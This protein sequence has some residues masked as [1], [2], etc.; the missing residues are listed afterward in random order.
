MPVARQ[1][2]AHD[3]TV[4][5]AERGAERRGAVAFVI[6]RRASRDPRTKRQPG[7]R[8]VQGLPRALLVSA[9]HPGLV[10]R[11]QVQTHDIGK[12]LDEP[13]VATELESLEEVRVPVGSLPDAVNRV[14]APAGGHGPAPCAP[15]G[16]VERRRVPGCREDRRD[17]ARSQ[18]RNASGARRV[19]FQSRQPKRQE[20]L[21]PE[22]HGGPG[23]SEPPGDVLA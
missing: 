17:L 2:V 12:L 14:L 15:R 1:A 8:P 18:A 5:P 23:N 3:G 16:G 20:A 4:E 11:M 19:L 13:L 7:R 6:V 22:R 10:G 9:K 21:S